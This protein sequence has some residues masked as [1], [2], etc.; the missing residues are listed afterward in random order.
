[1]VNVT[2]ITKVKILRWD[3]GIRIFN[4]QGDSDVWL[5][6]ESIARF[7]DTGSLDFSPTLVKIVSQAS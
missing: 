1:M 5:G 6:L 7:C 4:W 2:L 3:V